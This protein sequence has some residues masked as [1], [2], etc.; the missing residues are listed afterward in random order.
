MVTNH[1]SFRY[2]AHD[3]DFE[4]IGTILPAAGAL[5]D[6]SA[7]DLAELIEAMES[8]QLC[9]I[10]TETSLSDKLAQT[11]AAELDSCPSVKI[12]PLYTGSV[13]PSGSGTD[14][15]IGMIRANTDALLSGLGD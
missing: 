7:G 12:L 10:F 14:S 4:I 1:D 3:Y 15:Y 5:A 9:T 2:L 13:G 6:P 11:V 8:N